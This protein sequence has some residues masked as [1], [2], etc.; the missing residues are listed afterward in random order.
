M[1]RQA[2][3]TILFLVWSTVLLAGSPHLWRARLGEGMS[4]DRL[5]ELRARGIEVVDYLGAGDYLVQSPHSSSKR[6]AASL[7]ASSATLTPFSPEEKLSSALQREAARLSLRVTPLPQ[8]E[9]G[10]MK[11]TLRAL[12]GTFLSY[13]PLTPALYAT[14][15]TPALNALAAQPWVLWVHPAPRPRRALDYKS[16]LL[17]RVPLLEPLTPQAPYNLT[18]ENVSVGIWDENLDPHPDLQGRYTQV[19]QRMASNGHG[20][21]VAGILLGG[22]YG[23]PDARGIAPQ[24]HAWCYNFREDENSPGR[25]DWEEMARAHLDYHISLTNNSYGAAYDDQTCADYK[26][27]VYDLDAP[28]DRV[29]SLFPLMTHVF[30]V[31]NERNLRACQSK[32]QAGY[33]SSPSR[34]KNLLYVGAV[35]EDRAMTDFSSWGPTDDGR[36]LPTVVTHG[37][38][39]LSTKREEGYVAYS[40]T[41]MATPVATGI[42]ALATQFYATHHA[43]DVPRSD[44]LRAL[45]ANGADDLFAPGPDYTSGYGLVNAPNMIEMLR[46]GWFRLGRSEAQGQRQTYD[47]TVPEGT[48]RVRVMLV[49][50]DAVSLRPHR[51]GDKALI[52]D[53]DLRVSSTDGLVLPWTLNPNQPSAAASRGEDHLNNIEQ[54]TLD[55]PAHTLHLEVVASALPKPAQEWALVWFF[56]REATPAFRLPRAGQAVGAS[57][58]VFV[59]GLTLPV[60]LELLQGTTVVSKLTLQR[61]ETEVRLPNG[62]TGAFRLRAIDRQGVTL[63]SPEVVALPVPKDLKLTEEG[64]NLSLSWTAVSGLSSSAHYS[65]KMSCGADDPWRE[66]AQST[67]PSCRLSLPQLFGATRVALAVNVVIDAQ[68]GALSMPVLTAPLPYLREAVLFWEKGVG[69]NISATVGGAPI[70][71]GMTLPVGTTVVLQVETTEGKALGALRVNHEPIDFAREGKGR[72]RAEFTIPHAGLHPVFRV[73]AY[74]QDSDRREVRLRLEAGEHGQYVVVRGQDTLSDGA[75]LTTGTW[76]RLLHPERGR[77]QPSHFLLNGRQLEGFSDEGV[78]SSLY[79]VAEEYALPELHF[80]CAYSKLPTRPLRCVV[81]GGEAEVVCFTNGARVEEDSLCVQGAL[82]EILVRVAEGYVLDKMRCEGRALQV[83][84]HN[85]WLT[86]SCTVPTSSAAPL[87]V[88]L[89]LRALP[90][91]VEESRFSSI[92]LSPQPFADR[93]HIASSEPLVGRYELLTLG[94][95]VVCSGLLS[96]HEVWVDT[97]S[98]PAGGYIMRFYGAN[99]LEKCVRVV[100]Y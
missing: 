100:K 46:Q 52:N 27:M 7:G 17:S 26:D 76:L 32:Y 71:S 49:W 35:A 11:E 67:S 13:D 91:P 33:A 53:L 29:A 86:G 20:T 96:G 62:F 19:E 54:V 57:C 39:V 64:D 3:F 87:R 23:N 38:H 73:T 79:R 25:Q 14:L 81:R 28:Y 15:P 77:Y 66:V 59:E 36:L 72:Y 89:E 80:A 16:K 70:A 30:A 10:A 63:L 75:R 55:D 42:L 95:V 8:T 45:A 44:L 24:A 9:L 65:V 12:G 40:G 22:G 37:D 6:V 83:S 51:W 82:L 84:R 56:E 99:S 88:D 4:V 47:L 5:T 41:S 2:L 58:P 97:E 43:G 48:T 34:G 90:T 60:R 31:G 74:T 78:Y 1:M 61:A 85:G 18:G 92:V 21:H 98:L 68:E 94:G 50:N 69:A 93:L